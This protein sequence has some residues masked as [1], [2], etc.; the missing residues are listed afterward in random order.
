MKIRIVFY[1]LFLFFFFYFFSSQSR[2]DVEV[3]IYE[4]LPVPFGL[5][6]F[7][8]APDHPE[9]KVRVFTYI[10]ISAHSVHCIASPTCSLVFHLWNRR[11]VNENCCL[12]PWAWEKRGKNI[13]DR[14]KTGQ[15]TTYNKLG[16]FPWQCCNYQTG[17]S[18]LARPVESEK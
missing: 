2:Q 5:V 14:P 16:N 4:R 12:L 13:F 8:V 6:R 1:V 11:H 18:S 15:R 17:A 10:H 3:D 7:G 9:V